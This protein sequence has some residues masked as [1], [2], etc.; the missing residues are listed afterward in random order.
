MSVPITVQLPESLYE[1]VVQASDER[2]VSPERVVIE[3]LRLS[4]LAPN[5]FGSAVDAS[6]PGRGGDSIA[7]VIDPTSAL[8]L[9]TPRPEPASVAWASIFTDDNDG[10]PL[11]SH[12][13]LRAR[14]PRLDPPISQTVGEMREDRL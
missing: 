6:L 11:L 1:R 10:V 3:T 7:D 8:E 4:F 13:E 2:G 5:R 12:E 9:H 14:M